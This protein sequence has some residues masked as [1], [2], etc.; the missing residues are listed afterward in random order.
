MRGLLYH[1]CFDKALVEPDGS[2]DAGHVSTVSSHVQAAVPDADLD[3]CEL[4]ISVRAGGR[5]QDTYLGG[6]RDTRAETI[7]LSPVGIRRAHGSG[8][9]FV[10]LLYRRE[11]VPQYDKTVGGASASED[12]WQCALHGSLIGPRRTQQH[13]IYN[14]GMGPRTAVPSAQ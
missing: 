9:D 14:L 1:W 3:E 7:Q 12:S 5:R 4:D 8:K 6:G 13:G 10:P 11:V 2:D